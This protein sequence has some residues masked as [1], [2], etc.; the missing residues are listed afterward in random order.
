MKI[1]QSILDL[2]VNKLWSILF[3]TSDYSRLSEHE[4]EIVYNDEVYIFTV[5]IECTAIRDKHNEQI[6]SIDIH[7]LSCYYWDKT[8]IDKDYNITGAQLTYIELELNLYQ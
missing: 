5:S 1:Q 4:I 2:F 8:I 3:D 6:E 7:S